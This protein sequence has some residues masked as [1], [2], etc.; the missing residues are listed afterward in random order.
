MRDAPQCDL[1]AVYVNNGGGRPDGPR[2]ICRQSQWDQMERERP[3]RHT[4]VRD[5]IA[6]EREAETLARA[7]LV[8][9]EL[10]QA[11]DRKRRREE[12]AP[13]PPAA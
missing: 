2:V 8:A 3:G 6:S 13:A 9:A 11:R 1:W 4:L 10:A 5:G 12:R 7:G